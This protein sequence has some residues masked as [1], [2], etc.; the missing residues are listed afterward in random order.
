MNNSI[1]ETI[2]NTSVNRSGLECCT[3]AVHD[4]S[5]KTHIVL[6]TCPTLWV[7]KKVCTEEIKNTCAQV[8]AKCK[9]S[10]ENERVA[11]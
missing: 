9:V 6:P 10:V 2:V 11:I 4:A 1:N 5:K 8:S 7:K 3:K